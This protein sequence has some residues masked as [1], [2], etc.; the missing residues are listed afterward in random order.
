MYTYAN[1]FSPVQAYALLGLNLTSVLEKTEH[2]E[3]ESD[4]GVSWNYCRVQYEKGLRFR[5]VWYDLIQKNKSLSLPL[6]AAAHV[7]ASSLCCC[8]C[9]GRYCTKCRLEGDVDIDMYLVRRH[10]EC[11]SCAD[12]PPPPDAPSRKRCVV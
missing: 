8:C 12:L 4:V 5:V 9:C 7:V 1:G 6:C 2:L 11:M 10:Y 3:L